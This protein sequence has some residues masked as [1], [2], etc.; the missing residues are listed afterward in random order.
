MSKSTALTFMNKH[1]WGSVE[2]KDI[3]ADGKLNTAFLAKLSNELNNGVKSSF[4]TTATEGKYI[5]YVLPHRDKLL[6]FKVNG[7]DGGFDRIVQNVLHVNAYGYEC[8]YD[9]Y[10]SVN[11]NLGTTTVYVSA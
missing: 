2:N 3:I 1:Y 11:S 5:F 9:V 6:T 4:T 10:K 8:M 7:F